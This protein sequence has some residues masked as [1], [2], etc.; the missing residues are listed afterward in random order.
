[1]RTRLLVVLL[2]ALLTGGL[3]AGCAGSTPG[4]S[5]GGGATASPGGSVSPSSSPTPPSTPPPSPGAAGEMTLT[6]TV[7]PGVEAGCMLM[8][9]GDKLYLLV[10]GDRAVVK[11]GARVTVRGMPSPQLVSY[12]QQGEPFQVLEAH[13]A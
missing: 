2:N 3:V 13:P 12:C 6:G 7:E 4:A 5:P 8:R 11:A 10:G 1:M 9:S